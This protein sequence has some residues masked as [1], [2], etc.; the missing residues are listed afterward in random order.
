M[1]AIFPRP[2]TAERLTG[3]GHHGPFGMKR[4][5]AAGQIWHG[6]DVNEMKYPAARGTIGGQA[7]EDNE[8]GLQ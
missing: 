3:R 6:P 5:G 2:Q 1:F 7:M 8:H 4:P